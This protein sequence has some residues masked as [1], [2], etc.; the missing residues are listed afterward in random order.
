MKDLIAFTHWELIIGHFI[1]IVA[2]QLHVVQ[3][4]FF[5]RVE[6]FTEIR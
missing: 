5:G 6:T 4:V 2:F 3:I 1:D